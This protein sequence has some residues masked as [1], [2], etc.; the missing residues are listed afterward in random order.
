MI[1]K[2]RFA[3][4]LSVLMI[5]P[6]SLHADEKT[7]VTMLD[8]VL[9]T[10]WKGCTIVLTGIGVV[11]MTFPGPTPGAAT[12][13]LLKKMS[14]YQSNNQSN[15]HDIN[16]DEYTEIAYNVYMSHELQ[17]A[18]VNNAIDSAYEQYLADEAAQEESL[19]NTKQS[20]TSPFAQK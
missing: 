20:G 2:S 17:N 18:I 15:T 6:H 3:L 19:L 5:F 11:I 8:K 4:C 7:K 14:E 10:A 13:A 1:A 16:Y 12:D 9:T